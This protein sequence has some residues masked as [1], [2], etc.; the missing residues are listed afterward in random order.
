MHW[1]GGTLH[2]PFRPATP[3]HHTRRNHL[4]APSLLHHAETTSSTSSHRPLLRLPWLQSKL[5]MLTPADVNSLTE[6]EAA[7]TMLLG[8]LSLCPPDQ[9]VCQALGRGK[10]S[11]ALLLCPV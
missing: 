7:F 6:T 2:D 5:L 10:G 4:L 3:M 8:P 9:K 11:P 1:E